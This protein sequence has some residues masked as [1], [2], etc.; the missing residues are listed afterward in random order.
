[1]SWLLSISYGREGRHMLIPHPLNI[2]VVE[3]TLLEWSELEP[4]CSEPHRWLGDY[5][6]LERAIELDPADQIAL[7]ELVISLLSRVGYS[8]HE[9]PVGYLGSPKIDLET[10]DRIKALLPGILSDDDRAAYAAAV[11]EEMAAINEYPRKR[12]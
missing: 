8:T 2:R 4:A 10:L 9:L 7:R 1:M 5:A 6:H 11:A 3:P 12:S